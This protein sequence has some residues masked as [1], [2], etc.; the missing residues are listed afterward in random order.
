MSSIQMDIYV[1]IP[2]ARDKKLLR[3]ALLF[4]KRQVDGNQQFKKFFSSG[5]VDSRYEIG[6]PRATFA[7]PCLLKLQNDIP[8]RIW[9]SRRHGWDLA[10]FSRSTP[11]V[12]QPRSES[13]KQY[14]TN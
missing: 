2:S 3:I 8:D 12:Y 11:P 7:E 1:N 9:V 14:L 10:E 6:N 13:L 5:F 4:S